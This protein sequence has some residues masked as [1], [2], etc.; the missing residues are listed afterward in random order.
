MPFVFQCLNYLKMDFRG[1]LMKMQKN[2]WKKMTFCQTDDPDS[3]KTVKNWGKDGV[4][5]KI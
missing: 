1:A 4:E 5:L 3:Y 2:G